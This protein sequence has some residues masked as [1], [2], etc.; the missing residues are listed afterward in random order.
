[1]R[2]QK[3]FSIRGRDFSADMV[4]EHCNAESKLT[5]GYDDGHYHNRVIP[6][7]H[8]KA[9]G[10]NRAGEERTEEVIAAAHAAGVNG[11]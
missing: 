9:C 4:C 7:M 10:L 3:A 6:A 1:M 8:C 11:V 5:T 2:I